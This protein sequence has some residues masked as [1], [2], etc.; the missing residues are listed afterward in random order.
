MA[1][2]A[3]W[4]KSSFSATSECVEVR[5]WRDAVQVR[6]SKNPRGANLNF[7]QGEWRAFLRGANSGEFDLPE[8]R[9]R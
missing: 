7:T 5:H 9:R 2:G 1:I 4:R 6:D 8:N 3:R